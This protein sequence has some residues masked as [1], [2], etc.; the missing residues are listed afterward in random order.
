MDEAKQNLKGSEKRDE[1]KRRHK[2]LD[3]S[4][5]ATDADFC[6]VSKV[7]PGTVA[8]LDY[9]GSGEGIT[10]TEAIQYNEWMIQAPVFIIEG[11]DPQNGPFIISRYLGGNWQPNPP[12][13]HLERIKI[14]DGWKEFEE[15][16]R[17]LRNEYRKRGGWKGN[18][19]YDTK[20]E[21]AP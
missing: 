19:N 1:F 15:W 3:K 9:K 18:L 17:Y 14:V 4:F 2:D 6:L 16:E 12:E 7:P 8:Y 5:Y 13:V 20:Q 10:F 21:T 11:S